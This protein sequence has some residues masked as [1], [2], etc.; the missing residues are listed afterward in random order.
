MFSRFIKA[1]ACIRTS[2]LWLNDI[3]LYEYI[4]RFI[5]FWLLWKTL[6]WIIG[7]KFLLWI[8]VFTSLGLITVSLFGKPPNCFSQQMSHFIFPSSI[9]FQH[10][11]NFTRVRTI[12]CTTIPSTW[13]KKPDTQNILELDM[14]L[15]KG[16]NKWNGLDAFQSYIPSIYTKSMINV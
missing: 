11:L 1:T 12:L 13:G 5:P 9:H 3:A 14:W 8:D 2:F 10:I 6:L 7:Y 15:N 4:N 16:I